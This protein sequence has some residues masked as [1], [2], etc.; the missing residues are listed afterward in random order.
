MDFQQ[1]LSTRLIREN[2]AVIV[3]SLNVRGMMRN[4]KLARQISDA[5]WSSFLRMLKDKAEMHGVTLIEIGRFE[6]T[7]KLC[8][9]CGFKNT[10]LQIANREWVCTEC[11]THHD[12]DI[13]AAKNIKMIGL[14]SIMAPREPREGPVELSALAETMKQE[15]SSA[16]T[17]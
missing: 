5:A 8:S 9:T 7:S 11:R 16:K 17:G 14:R 12:R 3:E 4:K 1:K 10:A 6:S 2:Q 13:N 15:T